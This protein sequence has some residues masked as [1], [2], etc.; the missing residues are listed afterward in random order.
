MSR[1]DAGP[2]ALPDPRAVALEDDDDDD[3]PGYSLDHL[4]AVIRPVAITMVLAS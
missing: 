2:P 1:P 4:S 3:G